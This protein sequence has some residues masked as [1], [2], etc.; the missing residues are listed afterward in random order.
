MN[1]PHSPEPVVCVPSGQGRA[2]GDRIGPEPAA[3]LVGAHAQPGDE[4]EAAEPGRRPQL[5]PPGEELHPASGET[6]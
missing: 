2:R 4:P 6:H 1:P 5:L 3:A